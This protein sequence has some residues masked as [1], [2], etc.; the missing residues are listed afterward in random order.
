MLERRRVRGLNLLFDPV[1]DIRPSV[2]NVAA[3]SEPL[4]SFP[5]VPPL[6]EGGNWHTQIFGE[7][8]DG[9]EPLRG[10]HAVDHGRHPVISVLFFSSVLFGCTAGVTG[11]VT[12]R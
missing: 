4:W 7:L 10:F 1:L 2:S 3:D 11:L 8:L 5:P 9:E 6:V 12:L